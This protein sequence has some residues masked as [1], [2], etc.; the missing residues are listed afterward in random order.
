MQRIATV[1]TTG[2]Q[3][4]GLAASGNDGLAKRQARKAQLVANSSA[5]THKC[6]PL[7]FG[8]G[9]FLHK[10]HRLKRVADK[11][12]SITFSRALQTLDPAQCALGHISVYI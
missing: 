8:G 2:S 6:T 9:I 11:N 3:A 4:F 7:P 10:N 1:F 12:L 5:S